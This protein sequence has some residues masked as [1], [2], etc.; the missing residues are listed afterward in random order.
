MGYRI[1]MKPQSVQHQ[2]ELKP[3]TLWFPS[4]DDFEQ[5]SSESKYQWLLVKRKNKER[6]DRQNAEYK[7]D[8]DYFSQFSGSQA[9][10]STDSTLELLEGEENGGL[11][12]KP[13]IPIQYA[14]Y[15]NVR[16][17]EEKEQAQLVLIKLLFSMR[18]VF[19]M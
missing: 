12:S 3:Q 2:E 15:L 7:P 9:V 5:Q 10:M 19:F 14:P 11:L 18:S 6:K 8:S 4:G 16:G 13:L 1:N 17:S